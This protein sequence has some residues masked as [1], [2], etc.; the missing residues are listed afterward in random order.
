MHDITLFQ[1]VS[2]AAKTLDQVQS[3]FEKTNAL[4]MLNAKYIIYS[5]DEPP[6]INLN[7]LGNGWFVETPAFVEDANEELSS[8][9][10]IDPSK[11]AVIDKLFKDQVKNS[12]YP[13]SEGDTLELKS[14]KA[15]E[16][17]YY[18]RSKGENLAV[19][20]EIYYPAGWKSFIDGK[21]SN[22]FRT[23]YVLR[24][25]IIPAGE[26]EIKFRFEPSSYFTGNRISIISSLLFIL[27]TAGYIIM[28]IKT[29]SKAE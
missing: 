17:I 24:G 15:N 16:L 20:S 12:S 19:F 10:R 27:M 2:G 22:Y 4:N 18:S 23:D 29:K 8:I 13:V 14:Y 6:L 26:H 9:N 21:E 5:P 7:A 25:M 1:T 3:V 11:V 28:Q